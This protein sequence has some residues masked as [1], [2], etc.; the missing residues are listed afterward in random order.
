VPIL[1][2][3][4]TLAL[5]LSSLLFASSNPLRAL[6]QGSVNSRMSV[7][8]RTPAIPHPLTTHSGT[9]FADP[10]A[11]RTSTTA[12]VTLLTIK[13][14]VAEWIERAADYRAAAA[15]YEHLSRLSDAELHR[16]GLSRTKLAHDVIDTRRRRHGS[17][18]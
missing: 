15:L 5:N 8:Q 10:L 9:A 18:T 11:A 2:R 4:L 13:V 6:R 16:R 17:F 3:R 7:Q 14:R 1:V 12:V